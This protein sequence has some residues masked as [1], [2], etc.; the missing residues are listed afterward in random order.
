MVPISYAH[1]LIMISYTD[2]KYAKYWKRILDDKDIK[3][4]DKIY[5]ETVKTFPEIE[6]MPKPDWVTDH[7]WEYGAGYWKVGVDSEDISD[8]ILKPIKEDNIFI[9]GEIIQH[10]A[11][12]EGALET[13]HKCCKKN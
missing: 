6:E 8:K 1:G 13:A 7:Y 12:I 10:Q 4:K 3:L 9:C 11:W 2:G 5:D